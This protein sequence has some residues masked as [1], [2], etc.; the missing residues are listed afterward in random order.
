MNN[1]SKKRIYKSKKKTKTKNKKKGGSFNKL[2]NNIKL[3]ITMDH[4]L[5]ANEFKKITEANPFYI[6]LKNENKNKLTKKAKIHHTIIHIYNIVNKLDIFDS[7]RLDIIVKLLYLHSFFYKFLYPTN[8]I[9]NQPDIFEELDGK[10]IEFYAV[11][12]I[13]SLIYDDT[14][15]NVI[16][17]CINNILDE[18][19]D[20]SIKIY[21][22]PYTKD[23]LDIIIAFLIYLRDEFYDK[24]L[25]T[26]IIDQGINDFFKEKF[27]NFIN[28]I[29]PEDS[30]D[31][32]DNSSDMD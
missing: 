19:D 14:P 11:S 31:D 12:N 16:N 29:E 1:F 9:N 32:S 25:A 5:R 10:N 2:T 28:K 20:T 22:E 23:K 17:I 13:D 26:Q 6:R 3:S 4:L 24:L 7:P 27:N 30:D 8:S 18:I 21:R 15:W